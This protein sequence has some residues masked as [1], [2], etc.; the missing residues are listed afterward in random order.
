M[1]MRAARWAIAALIG[2]AMTAIGCTPRAD[3]VSDPGRRVPIVSDDSLVHALDTSV[4]MRAVDRLE[5]DT[6]LRDRDIHVEVINGVVVIAGEVWTRHEKERVG[7]LV[8]S[9]AGMIDVSN[10]LD[11]RPPQ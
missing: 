2:S 7:N 4:E 11:V 3:V 1:W 8:R 6:L 5:L 10:E 9:V